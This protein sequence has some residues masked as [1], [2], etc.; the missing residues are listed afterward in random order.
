MAVRKSRDVL[1]SLYTPGSKKYWKLKTESARVIFIALVVNA[2]DLG[3]L[4]G[5][6]EDVKSLVPRSTYKATDVEKDLKDM[7][8]VGLIQ[9]YKV[10]SD[11]YI[12][13]VDFVD[14]QQWAQVSERKSKLP[15]PPKKHPDRAPTAPTSTD[16]QCSESTGGKNGPLHHDVDVDDD[17]K[18]HQHHAAAGKESSKETSDP[19]EVL[20]ICKKAFHSIIGGRPKFG[21]LSSK[22]E[23]TWK[24]ICRDYPASV[25]KR[26][27]QLWASEVKSRVSKLSYP[28]A[29]FLSAHEDW[30]KDAAESIDNETVND[31][32]KQPLLSAE[33]RK[34]YED[35]GITPPE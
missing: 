27:V 17:A 1:R 5:G 31:P 7:V 14:N 35:A 30:L 22:Y 20:E 32:K 23:S 25:I 18:Q 6:A 21:T 19:D 29:V 4:E 13:V 16:L 26:A 12:E 9:R 34:R 2:D 8:V 15:E 3:R 33:G 10:G 24:Q 11:W 28:L